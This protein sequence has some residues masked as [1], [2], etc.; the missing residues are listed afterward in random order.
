MTETEN[1]RTFLSALSMQEWSLI[2]VHESIHNKNVFKFKQDM[3]NSSHIPV[4]SSFTK[5]WNFL[6]LC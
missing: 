4:D 2:Q 3:T 6:Q 5:H 1:D